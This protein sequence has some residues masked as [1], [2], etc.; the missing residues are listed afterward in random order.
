MY[1]GRD[2]PGEPVFPGRSV[3]ERDVFPAE[4]AAVDTHIKKIRRV[5]YLIKTF[6]KSILENFQSQVVLLID[7]FLQNFRGCKGIDGNGP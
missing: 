4:E 5:L 1:A 6:F 7:D 3:E 2:V